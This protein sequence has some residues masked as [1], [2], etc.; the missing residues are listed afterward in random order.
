MWICCGLLPQAQQCSWHAADTNG[1]RH[2]KPLTA[3]IALH[4]SN[5]PSAASTTQ[6][7]Q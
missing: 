6:Q 5:Q 1:Q 2:G 3:I 7:Q 4:S